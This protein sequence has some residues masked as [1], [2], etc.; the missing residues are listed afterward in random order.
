MASDVFIVEKGLIKLVYITGNGDERIKSFIADQG[1]FGSSDEGKV[2][3]P[4]RFSA[5]S[6]E[7]TAVARLP[8]TW[9]KERISRDI[10]LSKAYLAFMSW[11]RRRKEKREEALLCQ[12]PEQR[13]EQFL[14]ENENL[15]MR[16]SQG[17]IARYL[18]ITPVAFSRIKRRIRG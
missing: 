4:S 8:A 3:Q 1:L 7:S 15:A 2:E 18:G 9:V 13:Y 17:D 16:I 11:V 6:I 5:Y 10:A 14:H 12:S